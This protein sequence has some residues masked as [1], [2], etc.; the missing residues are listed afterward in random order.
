[1]TADVAVDFDEVL[2]LAGTLGAAADEMA[3]ILDALDAEVY[4]LRLDWNG[5]AAAAYDAAQREWSARLESLR[6]ILAAI[7]RSTEAVEAEYRTAER[8]VVALW[9]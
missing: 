2:A 1:M 3:S 5:E 9:N 7:E 4:V 8:E 6:T